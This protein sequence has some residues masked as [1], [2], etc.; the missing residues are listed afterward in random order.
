MVTAGLLN[1][2]FSFLLARHDSIPLEHLQ[3]N[4]QLTTSYRR[5]QTMTLINADYGV[6][7]R[8]LA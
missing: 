7:L 8:S 3:A 4:P 5:T 1:K 2:I 6:G